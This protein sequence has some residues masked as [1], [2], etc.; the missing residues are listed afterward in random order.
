M[1]GRTGASAGGTLTGKADLQNVNA[2]EAAPPDSYQLDS[3]GIHPSLARHDGQGFPESSF[4]ATKGQEE[5]AK[6][7]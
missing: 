4:S 1:R 3:E 5:V 6:Q 2:N 7:R